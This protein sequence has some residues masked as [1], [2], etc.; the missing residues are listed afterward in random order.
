MERGKGEMMGGDLVTLGNVCRVAV[1]GRVRY[2]HIEST[3]T[4]L[5]EQ[6]STLFYST[7]PIPITITIP[8]L[9]TIST[10]KTIQATHP[11]PLCSPTKEKKHNNQL[12]AGPPLHPS[13]SLQSQTPLRQINSR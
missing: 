2:T 10:L 11:F 7:R 13:P 3:R 6:E 12:N 9:P 5:R 4:Y 1:S 8:S